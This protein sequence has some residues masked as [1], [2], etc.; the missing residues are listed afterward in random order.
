[1]VNYL[2]SPKKVQTARKILYEKSA[3]KILVKLTPRVNFINAL[4][5]ALK[6]VDLSQSY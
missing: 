4:P 6:Q 2:L 1:M 3:Q 5:A